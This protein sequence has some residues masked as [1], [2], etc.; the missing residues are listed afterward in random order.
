[1]KINH[2]NL[3]HF[4]KG[5]TNFLS[6]QTSHFNPGQTNIG[7]NAGNFL[8]GLASVPGTTINFIPGANFFSS[9]SIPSN[10]M[11]ASSNLMP[12]AANLMPAQANLMQAP[13]NFMQA[14]TNFMQAPT[15]FMQAPANLI[16]APANLMPAQANVLAAPVNFVQGQAQGKYYIN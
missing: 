16:P 14:P 8:S 1:M 4:L 10:F 6:G 7:Q 13:A 2:W 15:N 12:A 5:P 11:P 3:F 9:N